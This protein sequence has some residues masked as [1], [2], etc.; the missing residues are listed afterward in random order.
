MALTASQWAQRQAKLPPEDRT[1]YSDYLAAQG[2]PAPTAAP[3]ASMSP[4]YAAQL[5]QYFGGVGPQPTAAKVTDSQLPAAGGNK[6]AGG[7]KT[8]TSTFYSGSGASRVSVTVYSDGTTSS[9]PAPEDGG[10]NK[11]DA[12]TQLQIDARN[13]DRLDAFKLLE[14]T[15]N[16]YGLGELASTIRNYMTQNIGPNEASLLLKQSDAY[17]KRFAG[18]YDKTTGR[19]AQ[20][21][22]LLS[23]A[24]YLS[25]ENQYSNLLNAYGQ[26]SLANKAE[27]ANLIASDVAPTEVN[28]RLDLAVNQIKMADPNVM[29][30][31]KQFYPKVTDADLIGYFLKP[32]VKLPELQQKVTASE[33]GAAALQQGKDYGIAADRALQLAQ[34]GVTQAQAK[35]GY[36]KVATVLPESQKL[37]QIYGEANIPYTQQTAEEEFLTGNASAARKRRQLAQLETASFSGKSGISSQANPLAKSIQGSF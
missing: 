17:Q 13:A 21:K 9:T 23:E 25:L 7:E 22:N 35:A 16:A 33:I 1:S 8:A 18:N 5:G 6:P 11:P 30:T 28:A 29:A 14:D 20:G 19:L 10:N 26:G 2:A 27:F 12:L 31:L 15:F 37:S 24:E 3:A 36:E 32:D 34:M 4:L